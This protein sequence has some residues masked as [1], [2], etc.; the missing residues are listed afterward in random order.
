MISELTVQL[1][2]CVTSEWK[3]GCGINDQLWND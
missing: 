1:L 3:I 2:V